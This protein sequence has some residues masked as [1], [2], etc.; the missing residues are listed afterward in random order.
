MFKFNDYNHFRNYSFKIMRNRSVKITNSIV[1][2]FIE[3]EKVEKILIELRQAGT[4]DYTIS[5]L[6]SIVKRLINKEFE[7]TLCDMNDLVEIVESMIKGERNIYFLYCSF[8]EILGMDI[9][10]QEKFILQN[11][12]DRMSTNFYPC[13]IKCIEMKKEVD[14]I[15]P[16]ESV[17]IESAL[18]GSPGIYFIYDENEEI[19][20]IGKGITC[21][22]TRAFQSVEARRLYSFSKVEVY[23]TQTK[24]DAHMY[25]PYYI[26][27]NRPY[28]NKE[29]VS[30]EPTNMLPEL[31]VTK[32]FSRATCNKPFTFNYLFARYKV[33]DVEDAMKRMDDNLFIDNKDTKEKLREKGLWGKY[34]GKHTAYKEYV[35][36]VRK[37]GFTTIGDLE[38]QIR[39]I[40]KLKL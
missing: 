21:V 9:F 4:I 29:F 28:L 27:L 3:F 2:T 13:R 23:C 22:T 5:P 17:S 36:K 1:Q 33:L 10:F 38:E 24:A 31:S 19:A 25:E 11:F 34:D 12:N 14:E 32:V 35:K 15:F 16:L 37:L 30:D 26:T 39:A 8:N 40:K 6:D 18:V 7:E 20:Y